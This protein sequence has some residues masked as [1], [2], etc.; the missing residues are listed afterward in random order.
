MINVI[1]TNKS[2]ESLAIILSDVKKS[3]ELWK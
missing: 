3:L 1:I 2:K